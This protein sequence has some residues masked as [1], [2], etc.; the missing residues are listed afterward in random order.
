MLH[1]I[2]TLKPA[3]EAYQTPDLFGVTVAVHDCTNGASY[4]PA[5]T[6]KLPGVDISAHG[7]DTRALARAYANHAVGIFNVSQPQFSGQPPVPLSVVG[8]AHHFYSVN[9]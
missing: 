9:D 8:M 5:A 7:Y 3:P 6:L 4:A 2:V 1:I